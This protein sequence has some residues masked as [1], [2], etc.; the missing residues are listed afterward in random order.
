MV[1][2]RLEYKPLPPP[3]S[4]SPQKESISLSRFACLRTTPLLFEYISFLRHPVYCSRGLRS[5]FQPPP[6]SVPLPN[7][8]RKVISD[9]SPNPPSPPRYRPSQSRQSH[10]SQSC[11]QRQPY[12]D[13][14]ERG[15]PITPR[16]PLPHLL[17]PHLGSCCSSGCVVWW[18]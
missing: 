1:T 6:T 17:L 18:V 13:K 7:L 3:S 8:W 12:H 2:V 9:A 5:T 14:H 16:T 11:S 15:R 4:C 10:Y